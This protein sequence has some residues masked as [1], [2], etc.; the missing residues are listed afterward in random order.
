MK[1]EDYSPPPLPSLDQQRDALQKGLGRAVQWANS[2]HLDDEPLIEACLQDRRFDRQIEP[3]RG[4]WLWQMVQAVGATERFRTPLLYALYE[5][6]EDC[7]AKQLCELARCYAKRG[8]ES[9]RTL[10]YQIVEQK[11]VAESPWLGEDEIVA[12]DGAAGFAFA[13]TIRGRALA[14]RGWDWDDEWFVKDAIE[15]LGE[16][17]LNRMFENAQDESLRG[18]LKFWR[19]EATKKVEPKPELSR[20]EQMR[21]IPVGEIIKASSSGDSRFGFFRG[22]GMHADPNDLETVLQVL[23]DAQEPKVIANL[24]TVFSNRAFPQF[25]ARVISLCQHSDAEVRRRA[26]GALKENTHGLIRRFAFAELEKG[27]CDRPLVSLFINNYEPGD[28]QRI[29][30]AMQLPADESDLHWLLMDV[31]KVLEKNPEADTRQLAVVAYALTPCENC[32]FHA[33]RLLHNRHVIPEWMKTECRYD[34]SVDCRK[35]LS[36]TTNERLSAV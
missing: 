11:P 2:G 31:T 20:R 3:T 9:F 36:S 19:H 6:S 5:L 29:L 33:V 8:D 25:D 23:W 13:A 22:W 35:L 30:E 34:S 16:G 12:L 26:F 24:L 18:Y 15:R 7:N 10:L 17:H 14:T 27:V 4:D 21:M 1:F 28:E 32:R